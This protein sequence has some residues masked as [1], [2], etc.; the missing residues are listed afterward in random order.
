MSADVI[1][2]FTVAF[3]FSGSNPRPLAVKL[4]DNLP[5]IVSGCCIIAPISKFVV[6]IVALYVAFIES[7]GLLMVP[8]TFVAPRDV[9]NIR[10][11]NALFIPP[12]IL[13]VK[14]IVLGTVIFL[15]IVPAGV[16]ATISPL[17]VLNL[18][19][20]ISAFTFCVSVT[21]LTIPAMSMLVLRESLN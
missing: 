15:G 12:F 11:A 6:E 19:I 8:F 17:L 18:L 1:I 9:F 20:V 5:I 14:D 2:P 16:N 21:L 4:A 7:V 10:S 13:P 3:T